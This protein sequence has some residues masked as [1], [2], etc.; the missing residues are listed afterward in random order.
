MQYEQIKI[1]V[2]ADLKNIKQYAI[3]KLVRVFVTL[4][5]IKSSM[6]SLFILDIAFIYIT[7]PPT[8][9]YVIDTS[10]RKQKNKT[11]ITCFCQIFPFMWYFL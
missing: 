9:L 1:N 2:S 3:G 6:L 10:F 5:K 11:S 7:K 8:N 4:N